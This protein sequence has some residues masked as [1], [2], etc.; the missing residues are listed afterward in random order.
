MAST[1]S[2][3]SSPTTASTT[4]PTRHDDAGRLRQVHRGIQRQWTSGTEIATPR[5]HDQPLVLICQTIPELAV[6]QPY[7]F[8]RIRNYTGCGALY[9]EKRHPKGEGDRTT[10]GGRIWTPYYTWGIYF[11]NSGMK[12]PRCMATS[13]PHRAGAVAMPSAL[14][15]PTAWKQPLHRQQRQPVRPA[16]A[17]TGQPL[18]ENIV[19]YTDPQAMLLAAGKTTKEAV[20]E[21]DHN[22]Y[23]SPQTASRRFAGIGPSATGGSSGSTQ[24]SLRSQTP[25][26]LTP[27]TATTAC[28]P[29]SP[30]F[31]S[32][33]RPISVHQIG[34]G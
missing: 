8:N 28:A 18:H 21:C 17:G 9:T 12:T 24:H 32:A 5:H 1:A 10:A 30:A 23:F 31:A 15:R 22:L 11:D 6:G 26:S 27:R 4:C 14:R 2:K 33:S 25:C 7:R 13:S 34:R 29:E 19:F 3:T 20:A 16:H